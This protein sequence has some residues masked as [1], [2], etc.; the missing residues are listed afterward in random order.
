MFFDANGRPSP[1]GGYELRRRREVLKDGEQI[2]FPITMMDSAPSRFTD[3]EA[4]A[5]AVRDAAR[6]ARYLPSAT[7]SVTQATDR[8]AAPAQTVDASALRDAVRAARYSNQA[9]LDAQ[10]GG[11]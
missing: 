8:D 7:P 2:G 4:A 6:D 3:A 10:F 11:D 9:R 5:R 1:N